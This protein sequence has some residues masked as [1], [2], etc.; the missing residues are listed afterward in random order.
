MKKLWYNQIRATT[1]DCSYKSLIKLTTTFFM[2]FFLSCHAMMAYAL[3]EHH[4]SNLRN[5]AQ[6][7]LLL[8]DQKKI[9]NNKIIPLEA[10]ISAFDNSPPITVQKAKQLRNQI[11]MRAAMNQMSL[12]DFSQSLMNTQSDV[13]QFIEQQKD[14]QVQLVNEQVQKENASTQKKSKQ[15]L[16]NSADYLT[17][18]IRLKQQEIQLL[19]DNLDLAQQLSQLYQDYLKKCVVSITELEKRHVVQTLRQQILKEQTTIDY[20][21]QQINRINQNEQKNALKSKGSSPLSQQIINENYAFYYTQEIHL[22]NIKIALLESAI[23]EKQLNEVFDNLEQVNNANAT[24]N[25]NPTDDLKNTL[26]DEKDALQKIVDA[27]KEREQSTQRQEALLKEAAK[28]HWID[29]NKTSILLNNL[30]Q[31]NKTMML[32]ES[33]LQKQQDAFQNN[34]QRLQN[35]MSKMVA[36]RQAILKTDETMTVN[37]VN[38]LAT[39]PKLVG[40][41]W[42]GL[43]GQTWHAITLQSVAMKFFMGI[44]LLASGF[45]FWLGRKYFHILSLKVF[46]QPQKRT[47]SNVIYILSELFRRNWGSLCLFLDGWFVLD[48]AGMNFNTYLGLFYTALVWFAFRVIMG[49]ARMLLVERET[50]VNEETLGHDVMLYRRLKWV[51]I[52]G[53]WVTILVVLSKQ[54]ELSGVVF[55]IS[56][57]LFMAFLLMVSIVLIRARNLVPSLLDPILATR[58]YLRQTI[59]IICWLLPLGLLISTALGV[60]GYI[61]LAWIFL[62]YQAAFV[63]I[64]ACYSILRGILNDIFEIVSEYMIRHL[65]QG[66][67]FSQ[68]FLKP[69]D[70]LCRLFLFLGMILSF[71][72]VLGWKHDSLVVI[73]IHDILWYPFFYFSGINVTIFSVFEMIALICFFFWLAKWTREFSYRWIFN[74]ARD[75]GIRN[76]LA[77]FCQYAIVTLGMIITLRVLGIDLTGVSMI[78]G[79]LA[80]GLGFGL[81]DFANNIVGGFMLLIERSVKEGDIVSV[82]EY[83]GEVTHIG[84][85]A[86][87]IRSWDHMEIMVPN[88]E[89]LMKTFVNWTHQ[90]SVVRTVIP[91]KIHRVDDPLSIQSMIEDLLKTVPEVL[92]NP[93]PEV[94]FINMNDA[95]IEF[96]IRY[97]MNIALNSRVAIRSKVLLV[98]LKAF[99][100]AGIRPPHLQQDSYVWEI[101]DDEN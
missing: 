51:F 26:S 29:F 68:A 35:F 19:S 54:L 7:I 94:F 22:S 77:V 50:E 81:R 34:Q 21:M 73:K 1:R 89:I 92:Q 93:E 86:M 62:Y 16:M 69:T 98:L 13:E 64:V 88:A 5:T 70:K 32:F 11:E 8:I 42:M 31:L 33:E 80:V 44:V 3:T 59:R 43:W 12:D 25:V 36:K 56:N 97:F 14:L 18:I 96:E 90:D 37:F 79:G 85:R 71:F 76:S 78:L 75:I 60:L 58:Q 101:H 53:G 17:E 28:N 49:I 15:E 40:F 9:L 2:L 57:R 24:T 39:L 91:M 63:L 65:D 99:K 27:L 41:Y 46:N 83:E 48:M 72:F 55:D 23:H 38:Q 87:R 30:S 74:N 4:N 20:W 6:H 45:V 61:T 95:L 67:L 82:G 66:W 84:I 52:I 47:A 10:E 100:D